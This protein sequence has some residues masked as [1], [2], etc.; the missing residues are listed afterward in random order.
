MESSWWAVTDKIVTIGGFCLSL[1]ALFV[2]DGAK[3]AVS[4]VLDKRNVQGNRDQARDLLVSLNGAKSAALAR[5][6]SDKQSLRARSLPPD[7]R[8]L[9][10]AQDAC[11]TAVFADDQKLTEA[12]QL[13][14][15]HLN[16]AID[17]INGTGDRN[18]WADALGLLQS[19]IPKVDS[20]QKKLDT[21]LL[22]A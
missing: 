10:L 3:K 19:L 2:A 21:T 7:K 13:T 4:K 16:G 20:Y 6:D 14:A 5:R 15:E 9:T 1:F 22:Q 17:A 11:A 8:A 18:G 12:L